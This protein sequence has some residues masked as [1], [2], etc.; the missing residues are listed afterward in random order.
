MKRKTIQQLKVE[1]AELQNQ[2]AAIKQENEKLRLAH[3][4]RD[5]V[6]ARLISERDSM[7]SKLSTAAQLLKPLH[8][9]TSHWD[10]WPKDNLPLA[11]SVTFGDL[12]KATEA[13]GVV[14][15]K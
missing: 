6:E 14:A 11:R 9:G 5:A 8:M 7:S 4:E 13:Y 3:A 2:S 12:R 1:I 15:S 10:G